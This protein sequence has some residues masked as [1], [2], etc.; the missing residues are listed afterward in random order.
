MKKIIRLILAVLIILVA[1]L[2]QS[3]LFQKFT[4][5]SVAPNLLLIVTFCFGFIKGKHYGVYVGFL[6]GMLID[7]MHG[8]VIGFQTLI[9]MYIGYMNGYFNK[10]FFDEDIT[11]PLVLL[12]LSDFLY[13]MYYYVFAFLLHNRLDIQYYFIH[14]M[15]PE[16]F[17]TVLI[18]VFLYRPLLWI[19]RK[20]DSM[21]EGGTK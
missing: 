16:L 19:N 17:F 14:I 7:L 2:L 4:F 6:C 3:T 18:T 15:M 20:F 1:Y 21:E 13:S 11:L 8:D 12:I 10:L 5:L 9:Y